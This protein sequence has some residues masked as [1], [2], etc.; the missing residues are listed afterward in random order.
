M[1]KIMICI[2]LKTLKFRNFQKQTLIYERFVFKNDKIA[3]I[4]YVT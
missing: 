2:K 3:M 4:E 1:H